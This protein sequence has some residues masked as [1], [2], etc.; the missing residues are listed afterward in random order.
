MPTIKLLWKLAGPASPCRMAWHEEHPNCFIDQAI[1]DGHAEVVEWIAHKAQTKGIAIKWTSRPWTHAAKAGHTRLI[2]WAI[3]QAL[4]DVGVLVDATGE[5]SSV[6]LDWWWTNSGS[7]L[8]GPAAFTKIANK[9]LI[10]RSLAVVEWWWT[11]FLEHRTPEHKFGSKVLEICNF[12]SVDI[13][14]WCWKHQH[15]NPEYFAGQEIYPHGLVFK[16]SYW[17]RFS[18]LKWGIEKCAVLDGQ[19]LALTKSFIISCAR[20]GYIDWLDLILCSTDVLVVDW[21]SDFACKAVLF[22]QLEALNWW[23]HNE[24][25]LPP[26][27][28]ASSIESLYFSICMDAVDVL[29]WWHARRVSVPKDFWQEVCRRA[30]YSDSW[31]VQLWMRDHLDLLALESDEDRRIFMDKCVSAMDNQLAPHSLDFLGALF[32]ELVIGSPLPEHAYRCMMMLYWFCACTHITITSL[33]PLDPQK[34]CILLRSHSL[35]M[36]EWWLQAHLAAGHPL[37]LP[38]S[39]LTKKSFKVS[40]LAHWLVYDV[41][42]TRKL[43]VFVASGDEIKPYTAPPFSFV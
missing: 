8:P 20:G 28:M 32:P 41:T 21:S 38:A 23:E 24:S 3:A 29:G 17:T 2:N 14:D 15:E 26:Q 12:S 43:S 4:N 13:L 39:E 30:I 25:R 36:F 34:V 6:A 19:K 18:I 22:G 33:L 42:V 9:A 16:M 27:S 40:Q 37:V 10:S 1:K 31:R 35:V 11:R 5:G 7:N